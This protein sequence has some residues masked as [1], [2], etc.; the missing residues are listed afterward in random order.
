METVQALATQTLHVD[1][2]TRV[3]CYHGRR[4]TL[5]PREH[6]VLQALLQQ[7]GRVVSRE[8]LVELL[9]R[10]GQEFESNTLEVHIHRL[11]RNLRPLDLRT[12]RGCG[13]VLMSVD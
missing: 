6:R 7:P 12:V 1:A 10:W 9:H 11:R 13:Y 8:E 5:T 4:V 3:A 2:A